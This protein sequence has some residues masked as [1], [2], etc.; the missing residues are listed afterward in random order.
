M[1]IMKTTFDTDTGNHQ[2]AEFIGQWNL[3][4]LNSRTTQCDFNIV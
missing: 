3:L 2:P 4:K 1:Y